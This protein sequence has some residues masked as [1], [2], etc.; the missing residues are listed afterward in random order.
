MIQRKILLQ[1]GWLHLP[2]GRDAQRRYVRFE[3]A[4]QP[5][6]ELYLGLSE[7]P[8][9]YCGMELN[10]Y[11]GQEIAVTIDEEAPGELLD[12]IQEGGAMDAGNPLYPDLYAERFRP[13]YHFSSRRGWLNDPNGLFFD[14]TLYHLYYQHNPY[15]VTHGGVNIHW[16][17]A[18]SRDGVCWT[19]R[20]DALRPWSCK[21]HIAS[22]SCIIDREGIAGFGKGAVIAAFTHL[23]SRNFHVHPSAEYPSEGQF[24]AYSTDGGNAF[25]LFPGNPAIPT[26]CGKSWRDPRIFACPDGGFGMA[27]YETDDAGDCVSFYQSGDLRHWERTSRSPDL[28][29]C[30]DLFRLTPVNGGDPRWVLYGADGMYRIGDFAEGAFRQTGQRFPLDFGSC[31]YA[32][33]TWNDR[34]DSDG[35]MHISWLRDEGLSWD[36][37]DSY[38]GMAF[39]Q[40]MTIACLL[41]LVRT[42]GGDRLHRYPVPAVDRLRIGEGGPVSVRTEDHVSVLP[43]LSGDLTLRIDAA[44]PVCVRAGSASFVYNPASGQVCFDGRREYRLLRSGPLELRVLTDRMSCEFFLQREIS[45]SYGIQMEGR[46]IEIETSGALA[47]EGTRYAMCGIWQ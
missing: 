37:A 2:I 9:F 27:V 45:T 6:A 5:F 23:G 4:G 31:T 38:P 17:H 43:E 13:Q 21:N 40:C 11:L 34:D 26:E 29:E 8:D 32:G 3:A 35:R 20:P 33:Q 12:G 28:Y 25:S 41:T 30:P 47:V 1:N 44:E 22:G 14:G 24:L 16:G 10:R 19:E 42:P 46:T 36:D 39:S 15:G 7:K 18:V